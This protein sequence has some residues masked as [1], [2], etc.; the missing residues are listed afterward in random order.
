MTAYVIFRAIENRELSPDS[1]V[2]MTRNATRQPPSKMG[3]GPGTTLTVE[4]ALKLL[5]VKSAND[6][7]VA[8]PRL[9][10]V[11]YPLLPIV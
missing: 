10:P 9:Y 7:A 11:R 1:T 2:R 4:N 8:L 3:Y 6:I 5:I